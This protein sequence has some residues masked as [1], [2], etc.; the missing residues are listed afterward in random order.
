MVRIFTFCP[1][2][3]KNLLFL[4]YLFFRRRGHWGQRCRCCWGWGWKEAPSLSS[5]GNKLS[6]RGLQRSVKAGGEGGEPRIPRNRATHRIS[7]QKKSM[8][9]FQFKIYIW[10]HFWAL[11]VLSVYFFLSF[12]L[13]LSLSLSLPSYF[14]VSIFFLVL[15]TPI[16]CLFILYV[17]LLSIQCTSLSFVFYLYYCSSSTWH[18]TV[19]V[20]C[21][22]Y[23][24]FLLKHLS[25]SRI[26]KFHL[27]EQS[28]RTNVRYFHKWFFR[29]FWIFFFS[30]RVVFRK[31]WCL[32][33]GTFERRF[34]T[35]YA[36]TTQHRL[37]V[38][39]S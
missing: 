20:A 22:S 29:F 10:M 4:I 37:L 26:T 13:C 30:V 12:L 3:G 31:L 32:L 35:K 11:T 27:L 21:L 34:A 16:P 1:E 17:C 8:Q 39:T 28:D 15:S 5:W 6:F 19:F 18:L 33:V 25:N 7:V 9:N 36:N 2:K 24:P 38:I 23:L 14:S